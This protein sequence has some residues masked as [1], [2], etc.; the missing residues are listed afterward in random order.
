MPAVITPSMIGILPQP[1]IRYVSPPIRCVFCFNWQTWLKW[2]QTSDKKFLQNPDHDH[3][4][5]AMKH[6]YSCSADMKAPMLCKWSLLHLGCCSALTMYADC[7]AL[8]CPT[9][10]HEWLPVLT[11]I[12]FS[13][14]LM[15]QHIAYAADVRC[16]VTTEQCVTLVMWAPVQCVPTYHVDPPLVPDL[17]CNASSCCREHLVHLTMAPLPLFQHKQSMMHSCCSYQSW[18]ITSS[19]HSCSTT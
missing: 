6:G 18:Q 7:C 11:W 10:C 16:G 5:P 1:L 17:A 15:R 8:P 12:D 19:E 9:W 2:K 4:A 14:S 13:R 3:A